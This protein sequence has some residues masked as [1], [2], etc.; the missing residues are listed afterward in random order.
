MVRKKFICKRCG[1]KFEEEVLEKGEA[2]ERRLPTRPLVCPK[3]GGPV[4]KI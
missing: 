4:E 2:E 3:C 1:T